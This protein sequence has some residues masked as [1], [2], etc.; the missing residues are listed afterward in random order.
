MKVKIGVFSLE[1]GKGCT[2]IASHIANHLA[3]GFNKVAVVEPE[4]SAH[5]IFKTA[6]ATFEEDGSFF[7]NG[8]HYYPKDCMTPVQED[9]VIVDQGY[10][11]VLKTFD[12][13]F[14]KLYLCADGSFESAQDIQTYLFDSGT[15]CEVVLFN[16]T[17]NQ[18]A[19]FKTMGLKCFSI[20]PP[21]PDH[22]S[23]P[24]SLSIKVDLLLRM[25]GIVPPEN[26]SDF[27]FE[28]I[29]FNYVPKEKKKFSLFG[30]KK[31]KKEKKPVKPN[32]EA[33]SETES[34]DIPDEPEEPVLSPVKEDKRKADVLFTVPIFKD[35]PPAEE[36]IPTEEATPAGDEEVIPV[37]DE[38]FSPTEEN[39]DAEVLE[40][41][42]E[43]DADSEE[44]SDELS[45]SLLS[46]DDTDSEPEE[47]ESESESV[48]ENDLPDE[49]S[50]SDAVTEEE[51]QKEPELDENDTDSSVDELPSIEDE[52]PP[53]IIP[54]PF[55]T[56]PNIKKPRV[57]SWFPTIMHNKHEKAETEQV[58]K[59][60][61]E[62]TMQSR[63]KEKA[64]TLY[65]GHLSIF[66][67][68]LRHGCGNSYIAGSIASALTDIYDKDIYL[69]RSE[70][71]TPLPD[72]FMVHD[73]KTD[74]DRFEAYQS[75][76]IVYDRG[77]YD[78]LTEIDKADLCRSDVHVM[79]C[80]GDEQDLIHLSQFIREQG[81]HAYNWL[82]I[83][84]HVLDNQRKEIEEAMA[85]FTIMIVPFHDSAEVP[86]KL[87]KEY[88]QAIEYIGL[89]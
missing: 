13:S 55:W 19:A 38:D 85:D 76:Y 72:N 14:D 45:T 9:M 58:S 52:A 11:N 4:D 29:E 87:Q 2:D 24:K 44:S 65:L 41:E 1:K 33:V 21:D 84:N 67:T 70:S 61:Q 80:T 35:M 51:E 47:L 39:L 15:E 40:T 69:E 56:K 31:D 34:T 10:V 86:A 74:D 78:E 48:E 66:V 53:K 79:V 75:G 62:Q 28:P 83:F 37:E 68:S 73:I 46:E 89:R 64:K 49:E 18:L 6:H 30:G 7:A 20:L 77:V 43:T 81:E 3:S 57:K 5:P 27:D 54:K 59:N 17:Q 8:V 50:S 82:Y 60:S 36:V 63:R 88:K 22:W 25:L 12:E 32:I 71:S 26:D 16:A 23:C 42:S